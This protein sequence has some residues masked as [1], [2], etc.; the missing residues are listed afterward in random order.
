MLLSTHKLSDPWLAYAEL[1]RIDRP[2]GVLLLLWPTLSA[3]WVAGHG[4]P[5]LWLVVV[6]ILG[7]FLTRS[8]GCAINDLADRNFDVLVKRTKNRPLASKRIKPVAAMIIAAILFFLAFLLVLTTNLLTV[9]L[10]F[11]ALFVACLYPLSKRFMVAPQVVLGVAFSFGIPMAFAAQANHLA[12]ATWLLFAINMLW[13]IAY[14]TQYAMVDRDDDLHIGVYSTAILFGSFDRTAIVL[15]QVAMLIGLLIFAWLY[16]PGWGFWVGM[17]IIF[18][19]FGW[20]LILV[21]NRSREGCLRA[22]KNNNF[23]GMVLFISVV[24]GFITT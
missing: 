12:F 18:A 24:A 15:L 19:L 7:V 14:D 22:F 6:F 3:L 8:A 10:A 11:F 4:K 5:E 20:Q 23:V 21:Y 1:L 13:T 9:L 16:I 17:P 2:I